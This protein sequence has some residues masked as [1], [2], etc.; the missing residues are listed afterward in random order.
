VA[1]RSDELGGGQLHVHDFLAGLVL[2]VMEMSVSTTIA[3][4]GSVLVGTTRWGCLRA[5]SD[6]RG[7]WRELV[8]EAC[9]ISTYAV[10]LSALSEDEL[11]GLI[12]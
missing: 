2:D 11:P 5:C 9:S 12:T 7:Y 3:D 8:A 1:D 4:G 6:R 10:E